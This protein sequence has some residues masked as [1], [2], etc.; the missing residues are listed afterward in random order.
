MN[1][2]D[3]CDHNAKTKPDQ[4]RGHASRATTIAN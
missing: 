1:E 4:P 2:P 3:R